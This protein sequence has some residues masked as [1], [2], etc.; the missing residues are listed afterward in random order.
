VNLRALPS[1]EVHIADWRRLIAV[2]LV[3]YPGSR[4]TPAT[5]EPPKALK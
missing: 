3:R 5:R 2:W 4:S 1:G